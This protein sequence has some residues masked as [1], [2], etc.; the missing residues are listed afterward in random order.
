VAAGQRSKRKLKDRPKYK[1]DRSLKDRRMKAKKAAAH[2]R[3]LG[4]SKKRR[5]A[6]T[7]RK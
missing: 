7:A 4:A 5:K 3:G 6:R 1:R 2:K